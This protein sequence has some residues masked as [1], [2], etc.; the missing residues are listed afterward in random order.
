MLLEDE[1]IQ[2]CIYGDRFA[3]K[4]LYERYSPIF[5]AMCVRYMPTRAE[6]EDVLIM[7]FTSIFAKIDTYK[8]EG[9]FESWM[10]RIIINTAIDTLRINRKHHKMR[11]EGREWD[12]DTILTSQSSQNMTYKRIDK[13]EIMEQ[14]RQLSEG[15]RT[16]FNLYAI[17]GYSYE[18]ISNML[19]ISVGT[20]KSQLAKARKLLQNKLQIYRYNE[21]QF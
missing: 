20:V 6:A 15:Y 17:E 18:T 14:I 16:V 5:F 19:E 2:K 9:A 13:K 10:K 7:G 3:Q 21:E 11:Y 4:E 1:L 8:H 12:D